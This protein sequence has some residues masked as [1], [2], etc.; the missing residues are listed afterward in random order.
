MLGARFGIR[1]ACGCGLIA[2][3]ALLGACAK[4]PIAPAPVIQS[5]GPSADMAAFQNTTDV[6]IPAGAILDTERSILLGTMDRW[7]G[8]LVMMLSQAPAETFSAFQRDMPGFGWQPITSV[9]ASTSVLAFTL[10]ERVATI[11]IEAGPSGGALVSI[12]MSPRARGQERDA[13]DG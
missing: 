2:A 13:F 11:E 4:E 12:I 9:Q 8:R 6:P 5:S 10:G 7:T 1:G 3:L